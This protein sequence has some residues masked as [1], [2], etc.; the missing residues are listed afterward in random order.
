M[1]FPEPDTPTTSRDEVFLRYLDYFRGRVIDKTRSLPDV[2]ES[3]LPSGWT[4]AELLKHLR[5]MERRWIEWRFLGRSVPDPWGDRSDDRWHAPEPLTELVAA[6]ESQA[7][8]TRE[9]VS[10]T[11]LSTLGVSGPGWPAPAT[12]ERV[13][14]HMVQEYARH[15]GHLDIVAEL[16]DGEVGE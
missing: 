8:R 4:P 16:A 13:L 1:D 11:S 7:E 12:L 5:H 9:V 3:R 15:L 14:F 10:S 6:L 2:H